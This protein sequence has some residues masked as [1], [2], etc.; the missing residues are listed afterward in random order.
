MTQTRVQIEENLRALN[1]SITSA[2]LCSGRKPEDIVLVAVT[3][4]QSAETLEAAYEAGI[5]VVGENRVQEILEKW[6]AFGSRFEWHLIGHLQTNKVKYI[7]DKVAM[8]HSVDS[9]R[10]AEE[11]SRQ[12][13][14]AG[15]V[16][17]VL[18]QVN[19]AEEETKFGIKVEEVQS[20]VEKASK[21]PGIRVRGLMMIAP[22]V[23]DEVFLRKTFKEMKEIFESLKKKAYNDTDMTYLSMGM[24]HDFGIAIEE[25]A[26]MIRV[27]TGIFG[28]RP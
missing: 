2:A 1:K 8:I 9:F 6:P 23:E 7:V 27:G 22:F 12:A 19:V 15:R 4:T 5:R 3:K 25:G 16:M 21:L 24:T 10:L 28:T 11:I 14:K 18:I 13:V 26:N 17:P 20:L